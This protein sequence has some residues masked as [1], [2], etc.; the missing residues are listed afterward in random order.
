MQKMT[1]G[2]PGSA[3]EPETR[4][5]GATERREILVAFAVAA[6]RS[7]HGTYAAEKSATAT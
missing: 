2:V 5:A 3:V 7:F 6:E 4:G 1:S